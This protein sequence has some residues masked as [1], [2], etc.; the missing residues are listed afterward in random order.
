MS[1]VRSVVPRR[2][3]SGL[4]TWGAHLIERYVDGCVVDG[5]FRR[6][7][8][9]LAREVEVLKQLA[10]VYMID[11]T[12]LSAMKHGQRR[13]IHELFDAYWDRPSMLP[14][15]HEH[16][17]LDIDALGANDTVLIDG[18]R[19]RARI[20]CDHIAGL[21]DRACMAEHARMFGADVPYVLLD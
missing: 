3:R 7:E 8:P 5:A 4:K 10:W 6:L 2:A 9:P 16:K 12:D 1:A 13:V 14:D 18:A 15:W 21:T 19:N 17:G 20:I 11:R